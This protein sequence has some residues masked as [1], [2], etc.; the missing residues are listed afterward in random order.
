MRIH[1]RFH[2]TLSAFPPVIPSAIGGLSSAVPHGAIPTALPCLGLL[3][4][5]VYTWANFIHGALFLKSSLIK[6]LLQCL[7]ACGNWYLF[8]QEMISIAFS[9]HKVHF[10]YYLTQGTK[11]REALGQQLKEQVSE[12]HCP[13]LLYGDDNTLPSY[14]SRIFWGSNVIYTYIS[15]HHSMT[16]T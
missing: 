15:Y 12:H 3:S 7:P 11:S 16:H 2:S 8:F 4:L 6:S 14:H 13:P 10:K 9:T 5:P 1:S